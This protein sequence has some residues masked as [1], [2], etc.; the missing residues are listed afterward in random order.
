[1]YGSFHVHDI[2]GM[3]RKWSYFGKYKKRNYRL[4]RSTM[5]D[6]SSNDPSYS[7]EIS[8]D[9]RKDEKCPRR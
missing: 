1:M 9:D 3:H 6:W 7:M 4:D 8:P 5:S 2:E